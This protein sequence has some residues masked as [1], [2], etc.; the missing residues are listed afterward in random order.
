M[1]TQTE[2]FITTVRMIPASVRRA[3][4]Q[5]SAQMTSRHPT[6]GR[7]KDQ[8][9]VAKLGCLY[10]PFIFERT[11]LTPHRSVHR[12]DSELNHQSRQATAIPVRSRVISFDTCSFTTTTYLPTAPTKIRLNLLPHLERS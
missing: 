10:E 11:T 7:K 6:S 4:L 1:E 8:R 5:L 3:F 9:T 12:F 2:H